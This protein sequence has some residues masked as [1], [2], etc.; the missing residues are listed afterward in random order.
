MRFRLRER[1]AAT[2][3]VPRPPPRPRRPPAAH[4]ARTRA[5]VALRMAT[6][7]KVRVHWAATIDGSRRSLPIRPDA[8]PA[9]L[10]QLRSTRNRRYRHGARAGTRSPG[11]PGCAATPHVGAD[12]ALGVAAISRIPFSTGARGSGVVEHHEGVVDVRLV[13]TF[14]LRTRCRHGCPWSRR[15]GVQRHGSVRSRRQ[16]PRGDHDFAHG[17]ISRFR[18]GARPASAM[19]GD[20]AMP[21]N[22]KVLPEPS[23]SSRMDS[24]A[25]LV[26]TA[27]PS[28][29][30]W[31]L[32]PQP[33][34]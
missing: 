25:V 30:W 9:A 3:A 5:R 10:A 27:R 22:L 28:P 7:L 16:R 15:A 26:G 4:R 13:L 20:T 2:T 31:H 1:V 14:E 24:S 11:S 29:G 6:S 33:A 19:P 32:L 18:A 12:T 17:R 8:A 23:T 21:S 34:S